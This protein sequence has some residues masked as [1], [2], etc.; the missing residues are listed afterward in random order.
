MGTAQLVPRLL[1]SVGDVLCH[2]SRSELFISR[3]F[4]LCIGLSDVWG[5]SAGVLRASG[6]E[7][8]NLQYP[9]SSVCGVGVFD[10]GRGKISLF[11]FFFRANCVPLE[12]SDFQGAWQPHKGAAETNSSLRPSC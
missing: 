4:K 5:E 10:A 8:R 3:K 2:G 12:G 6:T 7:E 9:D 1:C 11:F